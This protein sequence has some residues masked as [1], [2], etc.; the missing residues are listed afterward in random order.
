MFIISTLTATDNAVINSNIIKNLSLYKTMDHSLT[1]NEVKKRDKLFVNVAKAEE[2]KENKS[3]YW[4][5]L[6]LNDELKD[7]DYVIHYSPMTFDLLSFTP[8]QHIETLKLV[9]NS[10][11]INFT[12]KKGRDAK[13]YYFRLSSLKNL[14]LGYYFSIETEEE[15]QNNS[16]DY[17][18]YIL[19][20]GFVLGILFMAALYNAAMYYY[21]RE[22][23]FLYYI[24]MQ[25][26]MIAILI[27]YT[28][29]VSYENGQFEL[30]NFV[31][32]VAAFF[33]TL[34]VRAFLSTNKYLPK[35]DKLLFFYL[36]LLV[37]DFL[38]LSVVGES[39]LNK[40]Q[41]F[42]VFSLLYLLVG[43][44]RVR[45]GYRPARFFLI[46]WS[47][48][49]LS[50]VF[51]EYFANVV[52]FSPML[53]GA[54]FE[55]ILL[56]MALAYKI[57]LM[58]EEKEQQKELLIHQSKLA[59][60][61]E[62]IG[63]IAHQWRQPLTHLSYTVMNIQDAFKHQSLDEVYLDKKVSEATKQIEFMSQTIDAFKNFYAPT[64]RKENFS[65]AEAT[66]EVLEIMYHALKEKGIEV[67]LLVRKDAML[68]NYKNEYKQVLLNLLSNAKDALC[69]RDIDTPH[70][71]IVISNSNIDE[72]FVGISDNAGGIKVEPITKIFEP[73]F[74]TKE[75]NTGIG[76]YMSQMIIEKNMGAKL[77][78]INKKEGAT[79]K[80]IFNNK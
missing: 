65:L 52:S 61:G 35:I 38:Y 14:N 12:Y 29:L 78:V 9:G 7:G 40:L 13:I 18:I 60:M 42:S 11:K 30:Y 41:L 33:G 15:F 64:K 49:I 79:F 73:Y 17:A 39:L 1:L 45:Q 10:H 19:F 5:K 32:L 47:A 44:I 72:S 31:S 70:I 74:S 48:L 23:S 71:I 16:N 4:L 6:L 76:L 68:F 43:V 8:E 55:A 54:P 27:F 20:C 46:G 53:L 50:I 80:I 62:M 66:K 26:S 37:F 67:E 58:Q 56:A 24:F 77:S 59:S 34:F 63:N 22:K 69:E 51:S 36:I 25:F 28:G 75:T 21:N 2:L 57:K 3:T